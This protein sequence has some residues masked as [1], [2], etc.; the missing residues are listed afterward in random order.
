[1]AAQIVRAE[2]PTGWGSAGTTTKV[3]PAALASA[4]AITSAI[5]ATRL[6]WPP[7]SSSEV[8]DHDN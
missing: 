5:P 8:I 6:S 1:M 3:E 2:T 7:A 4:V